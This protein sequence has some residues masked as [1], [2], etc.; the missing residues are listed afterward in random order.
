MNADDLIALNE[1]IAG[2]AR[3][4]LPLDQGLAALGQEMARGRLRTVTARL[5]DDLKAGHTLPEA[6]ERQAG[7]IPSFYGGLINAGVRTGN[8]SS[9]LATLTTYARSIAQMRSIIVDAVFYPALVL[10]FAFVL[11]GILC[12]FIL[13]Q[14]DKIFQD[15]RLQL[16][17]VT[18][19][20][21][22]AS[23]H[24]LLVLGPLPGIV[25]AFVV[26][27]LHLRRT[28]R[29]RCIWAHLIYSIPI[30]G[31][32]IRSARLAAFTDLLAILVD[33]AVPLPEAF[34]LAGEASNDP[35]MAAGVR[36][37]QQDLNEGVPLGKALRGH[38]LVPEWVSW[39]TGL[40]ER[41]GT[42][43]K[44]LQQIGEMYRR[45]VQ[46]RAALLRSVFPPFLILCTAS[47]FAGF[48][49]FAIIFPMVKLLE[50]LSK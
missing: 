11:F 12:Y 27:R 17:A 36:R 23:R 6:L 29:G 44:T 50:G 39:M 22:E 21:L 47:V 26:V 18:E 38:G 41:R 30:A 15:F 24:P 13:P 7:D 45:Q 42:L 35:L 40:G 4:G 32:L 43:G 9:V 20:A 1:E 19:W 16:P 34:R 25:L 31:T 28:E 46:M 49:V 3:A 48:F 33:H 8:I 14:F 10:V 37:I 5:A 2:M